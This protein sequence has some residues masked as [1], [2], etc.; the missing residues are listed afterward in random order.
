MIWVLNKN[1]VLVLRG[2]GQVRLPPAVRQMSAR[3]SR[4]NKTRP[5]RTVEIKPRS[6]YQPENTDTSAE[7]NKGF[8]IHFSHSLKFSSYQKRDSLLFHISQIRIF[9]AKLEIKDGGGLTISKSLACV[10]GGFLGVILFVFRKVSDQTRKRWD[11]REGR[12]EE[13]RETDLSGF[14]L[15]ATLLLT[16]TNHQGKPPG[17]TP[18]NACWGCAAR[19]SES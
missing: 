8:P 1:L 9:R 7:P 13:G 15:F 18:G 6:S 17:S 2:T 5:K 12:D 10:A 19:F 14:F 3:F 11:R 16:F 4:K